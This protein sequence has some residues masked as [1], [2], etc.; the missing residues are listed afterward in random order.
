VVYLRQ[1]YIERDMRSSGLGSRAVKMLAQ[2]RFP[3]DCTIEIEVLASNPRGRK[4]WS[5]I[6][7]RPYCTTMWLQNQ[8]MI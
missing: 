8:E 6:G 5:Q 2:T 4:F 7:F 3:A 1:L